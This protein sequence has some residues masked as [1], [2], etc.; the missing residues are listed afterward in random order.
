MGW[1][2]DPQGIISCMEM[3]QERVP[4]LPV[5]VTE[6]G[7]AYDDFFVDGEVH[8]EQRRAYI[9][10]HIDACRRALEQGIP[11]K[12]YFIWTLTD[13]FEWS[14]GYQRKF[15]LIRVDHRDQKR[16]VKDS[17]KWLAGWL[18]E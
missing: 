11:L 12:G 17:G 7:A 18:A 13:N 8:D 3:I 5:Y 4:G 2:I 16:I 15:G 1:P 10:A 6:N 9:E 14:W